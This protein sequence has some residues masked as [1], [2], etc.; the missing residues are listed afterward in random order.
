MSITAAIAAARRELSALK[1]AQCYVR[2]APAH[3]APGAKVACHYER[4]PPKPGNS[5]LEYETG[6]GYGYTVWFDEPVSVAAQDIVVV[7]GITIQVQVVPEVGNLT[8]VTRVEG[9]RRDG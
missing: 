5:P 2:T 4:T 1:T 3:T 7:D 6:N 8:I 9:V